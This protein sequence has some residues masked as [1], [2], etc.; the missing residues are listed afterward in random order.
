MSSAPGDPAETAPRTTPDREPT[1]AELAAQQGV[2]ARGH[3]ISYDPNI[4]PALMPDRERVLEEVERRVA[5]SDVVKASDADLEW[6]LDRPLDPTDIADLLR[7]WCDL[8][9][10][11]AVCTLGPA[12]ALAILPSGRRITARGRRVDVVDTV[13]A[14]DSFMAGLLSGLADAGLLGG[15]DAKARLHLVEEGVEEADH[16]QRLAAIERGIAA[17]AL[18]VTRPGA[19][20]P[21]RVDLEG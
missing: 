2:P 18:T 13:G 4:R 7:S 19:W 3:T 5:V 11:L 6:L 14:G 20:A 16:E 1:P 17:S 8:G 10:A 21:S 15:A 12:G 9:P